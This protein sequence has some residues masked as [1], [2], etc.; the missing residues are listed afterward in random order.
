[1][2][3]LSKKVLSSAEMETLRRSRTPTTVVTANG[4]VRMKE[5]AQ[6]C[7]H[8]LH[9]FVTVQLLDDTPAVLSLGKCEPHE[10]NT[11]APQVFGE[12]T[13]RI[14]ATR[15]MRPQSRMGLGIKVS[16]KVQKYG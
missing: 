3:M 10:R 6:V 4:E 7:V 9:L 12:D 15:K 5:E 1:M 2:H 13:G 8:D 14:F 11:C 16:Y